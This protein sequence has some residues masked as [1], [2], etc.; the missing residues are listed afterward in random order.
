MLGFPFQETHAQLGICSGNSGDPIFTETF[1]TGFGNNPLPANTTTYGYSINY[2][3]DGSYTVSNGTF[4]NTYDWHEIADHTPGDIAGKSLIVN[5]ATAPGEFYKT[6]ILGL[7]ENTTYGF[8][9]WLINLVKVPGFCVDQGIAIPVNV[10]FEIWDSTDTN[11]LASRT[12]GDIMG[13]A[14]PNWQE[15]GVLFQT[16]AGQN[17]V[18]LKIINNGTG[19]CGNDLAIDDIQFKTCGDF[20]P[21]RDASNDTTISICS[22]EA[23]FSTTLTATPDSSVFSTHFYQWQESTDGNTWANI[24]GIETGN[25]SSISVSIT[26]SMLY[27]AQVAEFAAN[28]GNSKC[29]SISDEF[30]ATVDLGGTVPTIACWETATLNN[31]TCTWV[32]SGIQPAQPATVNCWDNYQFDIVA[33]AWVNNGMQTPQPAIINCWDYYQFDATTC[34]WVNSGTQAS[35]PAT[36]NCWDNYEFDTAACAWVNSG[37][38]TPQ[39]AAINCWDIFDF[40]STSCE[41]DNIGTKPGSVIEE[42]LELC[43]GTNLRLQAQSTIPTPS[44]VWSTGAI[45]EEIS[46]ST[47]GVYSVEITDGFCSFETIVYNVISPE[48]PIIESVVSNGIDIIIKTANS[49]DFLYSLDG[50]SYQSN[51]I[52]YGVAGGMY[53]IYVKNSVCDTVVNAQ[54]LHFFI[55]KFFTPNNDGI[56]DT[57]NLSGIENYGG[58][59]VAIY[60]RYGKLLKYSR[61]VAFEWDGTYNSQSLPSG[62]YWYHIIITEQQFTGHFTLKR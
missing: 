49:G 32:V 54:H 24:G 10:N 30:Q 59:Q 43:E 7:C 14:N 25:S 8:S 41:W 18:I 46:I 44:Y 48:A 34:Q 55:P 22:G 5:A 2:P 31:A 1:G 35:Q 20:I 21:V 23:P 28:L 36:V 45:S 42:N 16:L 58:T 27:R 56:N 38:Q 50:I 39:P 60:D 57:F 9:A 4:G 37:M 61:D 3:L 33:C 52:F 19:G 13:S 17:E 47:P 26:T 40:N 51:T 29:I 6:E 12:T 53:T 11:L 15:Y 62:D